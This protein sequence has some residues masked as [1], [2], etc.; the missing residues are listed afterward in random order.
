MLHVG[1]VVLV[2]ARPLARYQ[3]GHIPGAI[4]LPE[5]STAQELAAFKAQTPATVAWWFT[6]AIWVPRRRFAS[7]TAFCMNRVIALSIS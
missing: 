4:S 6:V 7:R 5:T 3:A 2:D 1:Q